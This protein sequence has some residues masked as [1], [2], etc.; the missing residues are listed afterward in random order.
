MINKVVM[1]KGAVFD[2]EEIVCLIPAD[3]QKIK[4]WAEK[5]VKDEDA[6]FLRPVYPDPDSGK[7]LVLFLRR[8]YDFGLMRMWILEGI[9][10]KRDYSPEMEENG[11]VRE[12]LEVVIE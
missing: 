9:C 5:S 2:Y 4:K 10:E 6:A 3:R 1:T 11:T 12:W 8:G 7:E